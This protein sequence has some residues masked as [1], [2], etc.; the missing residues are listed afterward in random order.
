MDISGVARDGGV[1][2]RERDGRVAGL[3]PIFQPGGPHGRFLKRLICFHGISDA[4]VVE[5]PPAFVVSGADWRTLVEKLGLAPYL[6]VTSDE[7]GAA[8]KWRPSFRLRP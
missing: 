7:A 3:A 4:R 5:P 1:P 2:H 6:A 8:Y